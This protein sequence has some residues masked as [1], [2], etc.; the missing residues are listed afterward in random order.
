MIYS[1]F[2]DMNLTPDYVL[3]EMSYENL[4]MYSRAA[5]HF[6]DEDS[7]EVEWDESKDANNPDNFTNNDEEVFVR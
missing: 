1:W 4:I 5:P 6:D 3:Y 7:K 2:K